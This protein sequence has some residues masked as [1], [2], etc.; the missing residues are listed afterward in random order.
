[1]KVSNYTIIL[2]IEQVPMRLS[3]LLGRSKQSEVKPRSKE[4]AYKQV[5]K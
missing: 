5:Y 2:R 4:K 3:L 1:M